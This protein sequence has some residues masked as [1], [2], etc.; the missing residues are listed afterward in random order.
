MASYLTPGVY[1][2][3]VFAVPKMELRTGVPAFLGIGM[4]GLA[5]E[6]RMLTG[7]SPQLATLLGTGYLAKAVSGFFANGGRLCAVAGLSAATPAALQQG[8]EQIAPLDTV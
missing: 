4:A 8:L 3:D 7:W 6:F 5:G 2:R 1:H